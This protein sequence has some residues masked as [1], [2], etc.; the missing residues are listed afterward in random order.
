MI[1]FKST[2]ETS[3]TIFYAVLF[4]L[5]CSDRFFATRI[6]GYNFRLAQLLL[7]INLIIIAWGYFRGAGQVTNL[8]NALKVLKNWIPFFLLYSLSAVFSPDPHHTFLKLLWAVFNIGTVIVLFFASDHFEWQKKGMLYGM[9]GVAVVIWLQYILIYCFGFSDW[10]NFLID[11]SDN[12]TPWFHGLLGY[13]QYACS[14]G[15][16]PIFRPNAFYYEP[17]YAGTALCLAFPLIF[18]VTY[19]KSRFSWASMI[20]P[21]LIFGAVLIIDSRAGV[22]ALFVA[23]SII[24]VYSCFREK[25]LFK[26]LFRTLLLSIFALTLTALSYRVQAYGEF[27]FKIFNPAYIAGHIAD[28]HSSEGWRVAN[29]V[30]SIKSDEGHL[31]TGIGVPPLSKDRGTLGLGQTSQGMWFE[32]LEESGILG[33][34]GFLFAIGM[35]FF[36]ASKGQAER[37]V[38]VLVA[39]AFIAHFGVSLNFTSTFPRLD[40]WLLFFFGLRL[41]WE[42]KKTN[43]F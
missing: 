22:S 16:I 31:L 6:H 17:S 42:N 14:N 20:G 9:A 3:W 24:A 1:P 25:D 40:Y 29:T 28:T 32:I 2:R 5:C 7:F 23:V 34:V 10:F 30:N 33:L 21:A 27:I 18:V 8:I 26:A 37:Y 12:D 35:N 13:A 11:H 36:D 38:F 43:S 15:N 39:A 4:F 19:K 41:L